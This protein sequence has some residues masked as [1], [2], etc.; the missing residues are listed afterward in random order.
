MSGKK[1]KKPP[2]KRD[3]GAKK[4]SGRP[5]SLFLTAGAII[6][7]VIA[8]ILLLLTLLHTARSRQWFS[9]SL[10]DKPKSARPVV[11]PDAGTTV[12]DQ[13]VDRAMTP[14]APK[15]PTV[16]V[17]GRLAIIIDDL[18]KDADFAE[19]LSRLEIPV[20]GAVLPDLPASR[21]SAELLHAAG[22]EVLLHVPMEPLDYPQADPGREPLFVNLPDSEIR[23]RLGIY[24]DSVPYSDGANNHMG[25]RFTADRAALAP[26]L[27]FFAE[28]GM[29]F[30]DSRTSAASVAAEE[31]KA[32]QIRT[33][34]RDVFLD[35]VADVP[36]IRAQLRKAVGLAAKNGRAI[37]I[38]HPHAAT[39]E[40]LKRETPALQ[41][42]GIV[43][44]PVRELVD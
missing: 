44:V 32:R 13:N 41:R 30:V 21:Q 2:Q 27:D 9:A 35:N 25:S 6:L 38:G 16:T 3:K 40:A 19:A 23:R 18:G 22:R 8:V 1:K 43:V 33:A 14:P 17:R 28:K 4:G 12:P 10:P 11:A 20:T 37:A 29:F 42:A 36:A 7:T 5:R 26:V 34:Q 24:L 31:A 15:S 39:L